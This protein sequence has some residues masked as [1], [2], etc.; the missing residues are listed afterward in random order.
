MHLLYLLVYIF[1]R[2]GGVEKV[3][4]AGHF[5]ECRVFPVAV[6]ALCIAPVGGEGDAG[7]PGLAG[8]LLMLF[9]R[10]PQPLALAAPLLD[11]L[12]IQ[13]GLLRGQGG[14]DQIVDFTQCVGAVARAHQRCG[15]G[16]VLPLMQRGTA[17]G[18]AEARATGAVRL[19]HLTTSTCRSFPG[20]P[21]TWRSASPAPACS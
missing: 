6:L 5:D 9:H 2:H 13:S 20:S 17:V 19:A 18:V 16:C 14:A 8:Q 10:Q 3:P 4:A 11:G 21:R 7:M 1:A 15:V 12:A